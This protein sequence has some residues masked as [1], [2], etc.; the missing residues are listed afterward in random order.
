M[1]NGVMYFKGIIHW[2]CKLLFNQLTKYN[3]R[4]I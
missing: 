1:L 2:N 3:W 4:L